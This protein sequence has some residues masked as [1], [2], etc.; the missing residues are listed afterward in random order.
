MNEESKVQLIEWSYGANVD[1]N[2]TVRE[3]TVQLKLNII[4]C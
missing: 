1:K 3:D 4:S 2:Y